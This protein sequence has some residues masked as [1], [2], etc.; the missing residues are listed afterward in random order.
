VLEEAGME[1]NDLTHYFSFLVRRED[2]A[3]YDKA[4]VAALGDAR[5]ASTK[6][7]ISGL[8]RPELL[9]EVQ[10]FAARKGRLRKK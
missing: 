2:N 1:M 5:P 4:R 3:G 6:V 9:C 8:A 7:F 10:A